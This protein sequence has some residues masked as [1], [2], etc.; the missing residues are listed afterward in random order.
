M[1]A[2]KR[3]Y[4]RVTSDSLSTAHSRPR[5]G[6]LNE[7]PPPNPKDIVSE[8]TQRALAAGCTLPLVAVTLLDPFL[9]MY[10]VV[11][12]VPVCTGV[13]TQMCAGQR[14]LTVLGRPGFG[15]PRFRPHFRPELHQN[16]RCLLCHDAETQQLLAEAVLERKQVDPTSL[17]FRYFDARPSNTD[18]K[19]PVAWLETIGIR[20]HFR[21]HAA[22]FWCIGTDTVTGKPRLCRK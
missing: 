17:Q 1:T 4:S 21:R 22:R 15:L 16:S 11:G 8:K 20:G 18:T 9:T 6:R 5:L 19:F 13:P 7:H 14:V 12:R 2:Q 10:P 3:K